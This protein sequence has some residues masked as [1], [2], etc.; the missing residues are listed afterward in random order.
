VPFNLQPG[1][2]LQV[3]FIDVIG[4]DP[5]T[6]HLSVSTDAITDAD[7]SNNDYPR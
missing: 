7:L 5:E 2:S 6:T 1:E 3:E 4:F